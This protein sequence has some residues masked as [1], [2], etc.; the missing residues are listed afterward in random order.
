MAAVLLLV[1]AV[2]MLLNAVLTPATLGGSRW[3]MVATAA[4]ALVLTVVAVPVAAAPARAPRWAAAALALASGALVFGLDVL[5]GDTTFGAQIYLGWPVLYAAYHLRRAMAWVTAGWCLL[6]QVVLLLL[7][8]GPGQVQVDT[9]AWA[10]SFAAI[11]WLLSTARDRSDALVRRLRTE[12]DEDAMTGV[13]SRRAFTRALE[14]HLAAGTLGGLLLVDVDHFKQINDRHGH[15]A[16]D[17]VLRQVAGQLRAA[18]RAEDVVGRLGGDEFAVVLVEVP[19]GP[20]REGSSCQVVQHAAERFR[21]GVAGLTV[22]GS[23]GARV[24]VSVGLA[25][26]RAGDTE[27]ALL[28]RADTAMYEA[29]RGGRN[30]IADAPELGTAPG[31]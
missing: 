31:R 21:A 19:P 4:A 7:V 23:G 16:G 18:V 24:S 3:G 20:S 12:A 25:G 2:Y 13:A 8:A 10:T 5:T 22:A 29:K 6:G 27:Q 26:Y 9:P 11:T 1:G 17:A 14:R 15:A 30:R 28:A